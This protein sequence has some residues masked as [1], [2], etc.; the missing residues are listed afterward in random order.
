MFPVR[1]GVLVADGV[2]HFCAGIFPIQGVYQC[3]VDIRGGREVDCKRIAASPQGYMSQELGRLYVPTGRDPKGAVLS[4]ARRRGKITAPGLPPPDYPYASITAGAVR[5]AGGDGKVVAL[6]ANDG[7][8]LWSADVAGRAYGLAAARGRLLVSTDEG[9]VYCFTPEP[10]EVAVM[11]AAA[12]KPAPADP[13]AGRRAHAA[14]AAD[15][16]EKIVRA[17]GVRRGYGLLLGAG[18]APL[19]CEL[20]QCTELRIVLREPDAAKVAAVRARLDA[21]GLYGSGIVVHHGPLDRLPYADSLFNLVVCEPSAGGKSSTPRKEVVRVLRPGRGAAFLSGQAG[22]LLRRELPAGGG[23]WTHTWGDAG[24]T[25]CS[26]DRLVGGAMTVQWFGR[27][28]PR[29]MIDR[30]HR[31]TPPL[32][33]NGVLFVPGDEVIFAVDAY[34]GTILWK[35]DVPNSRRLGVFLDCGSMALDDELLYVLV[36]E[37]CL[38]L[39]VRSGERRVT[40]TMP[41]CAPG[42]KS[43]W[44]Y[45]ARTGDVVVG[46]GRKGNATYTETSW[47]ADNALWYDNMELVTS[48]YLFATGRRGGPARWT[49]ASG[50]VINPT[51]TIGGGRVYFVESHAP[52]ALA[53]K[54]GRMTMRTFLPGPNWLVALDLKTGKA[55]WKRKLDLGNC[56]HIVYLSYAGGRLVLSGNRYVEDRLWYW[57]YGIDAATGEESWQ[58]AHNTGFKPK[59]GHGEQNRHPTIVGRTVYAWPLAYDLHTGEP[60][61]GWKFSRRGGGCG[62]ISASAGCLFW[63]GANPWMWDLRPGG[64]PVRLNAVSRPGCF[65][66]IIP[67]GGLVLIPEASSGCTCD[68]PIQASMALAPAGAP[69][70]REKQ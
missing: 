26:G 50:L 65:I 66:N 30:H 28:G 58:Q 69:A 60:L 21:A 11:A 5:V 61:A 70:E 52:A 37:Q 59:G 57:F 47:D 13:A 68:Y 64:G 32:C 67:A 62:N 1:T 23:E 25:A 63:R 22:E 27:P 6:D 3:A 39:D 34:N 33:K 45:L 53:D 4:K 9:H 8:V 54:L 20:A 19:A 12:D 40:L 35:A 29:E 10:T 49:Y 48:D 14:D 31:N 17:A 42:R 56:Q 38:G 16:A 36:R 46:S 18:C 55:A 44:G 7:A 51:I 2:A 41:Q 24:N 15:A 43:L